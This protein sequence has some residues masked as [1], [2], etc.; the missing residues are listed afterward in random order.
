M[1]TVQPSIRVV[2]FTSFRNLEMPNLLIH[3]NGTFHEH[4]GCTN[5]QFIAYG[6]PFMAGSNCNL[7]SSITGT[8]TCRLGACF[9]G[10]CSSI[11]CIYSTLQIYLHIG[12]NS[13]PN[14]TSRSY[15]NVK[16]LSYWH[17]EKPIKTQISVA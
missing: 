11:I 12:S 9:Y 16:S 13:S 17:S 2:P 3:F 10:T 4:L 15:T 14:F 6:L 5:I 7:I 8:R 1:Q